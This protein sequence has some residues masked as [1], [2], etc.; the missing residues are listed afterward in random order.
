MRAFFHII[1]I[2]YEHVSAKLATKPKKG[3]NT[4][5]SEKKK[6]AINDSK[7]YLSWNF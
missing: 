2:N 6:L 4:N 5:K 7:T 1:R 3:K